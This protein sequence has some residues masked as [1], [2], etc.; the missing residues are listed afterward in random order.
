MP[1]RLL[2]VLAGFG[3]AIGSFV[4]VAEDTSAIPEG[5]EYPSPE[6]LVR[7]TTNYL[8][9]RD[10]ANRE[11]TDV[12]FQVRL[13]EQSVAN[14]ADYAT[15]Q[16]EHGFINAA[17]LCATWAE[18]CAGDPY[19]YPGTDPFYDTV[20]TVTETLFY[21]RDC[22]RIS[23][24]VWAPMGA[25]A[26]DDLPGVVITNGSIQ[27]PETL[28]WWFAQALVESGYVVMTW[29]PRGQGRSD[30]LAP[31][32]SA[33][34]NVDPSVFWNGTVDAIDFFHATPDQTYPHNQRCADTVSPLFALDAA[35][36]FNPFHDIVDPDR[37]G[38]AGHSLGASAV[39]TVQ[40][41]DPW[42]GEID[43]ANPVDVIVAWDSLSDTAGDTDAPIVPRVPA[44]GQTSEYGIL[45]GPHTEPPD[46]MAHLDGLQAWTDADVP[47][48]NQTILGSTHFEWS[49]IPTRPVVAFSA[50][51]WEDWGRPMAEHYSVA[52]MDRWL[53]QSDEPGFATAD[54]R[55]LD[56]ATFCERHSFYYRS[57]RDFPD[58]SGQRQL[59]EDI[60]AGCAAQQQGRADGLAESRGGGLG[61]GLLLFLLVAAFRPGRCSRSVRS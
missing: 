41:Y 47:V 22:A 35:A 13:A 48:V 9:T 56:D 54:Q 52:W 11:L 23:G 25:T 19:R 53:K 31:D 15:F 55:L 50:T 26:G 44:L 59:C 45:G 1:S 6:W 36:P 30:T 21:D 18:T 58:R 8:R 17:N 3:L 7:E 34:S 40:G 2:L 24:R 10:E 51:S 32:G 38:L 46:P 37:L 61:G 39:T 20:G 27:A 16:L 43:D 29:D 57:A 28:Y 12:D 4:V 49:L 14:V 33:G 42:P 5:P 60:R